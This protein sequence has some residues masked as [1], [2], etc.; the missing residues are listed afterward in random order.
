ML[1][2]AP[3]LLGGWDAQ[4]GC[5]HDADDPSHRFPAGRLALAHGPTA[6]ARLTAR[7]SPGTVRRSTDPPL[8]QPHGMPSAGRTTALQSAAGPAAAEGAQPHAAAESWQPP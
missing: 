2:V 6:A 8:R 3:V 1:P 4:R 7:T 5:V